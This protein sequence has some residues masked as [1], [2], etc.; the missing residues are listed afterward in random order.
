MNAKPDLS[1]TVGDLK[2]KNPII[3]GSGEMGR[4]ARGLIKYAE[5][6]CSAVVSKSVLGQPWGGNPAPWNTYS[7][8][9]Y[10]LGS[11]GDPGIGFK[12]MVPEIKKAKEAIKDNAFVEV[13]IGTD[14][15]EEFTEMAVEFEKAGADVIE[16]KLVG[17]PNYRP[18]PTGPPNK[19]A[20][21]YWESTPEL[22]E[23]AVRAIKSVVKIPVWV[24]YNPK[25]IESIRA[26]ERGG[27][28]G[29]HAVG[30]GVLVRGLTMCTN[31]KGYIGQPILGDPTG[32]GLK[33]FGSS[34]YETITRIAEL[35]RLTK[36]PL[37]PSGGVA[38]ASDVIQ[39][40]MAGAAAV[41]VYT[42]IAD[43]GLKWVQR[44]LAD[45][46]EWMVEMGVS[47]L[48]EIRGITLKYLPPIAG[49]PVSAPETFG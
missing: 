32:T 25:T 37:T 45:I 15:K 16:L 8:K 31:I 35:A 48:D 41:Q 26:V 7:A 1:V 34:V 33:N 46:E 20:S 14:E 10:L 27:A 12:A 13:S 23:E 36:L 43:G 4:T 2:L 28:N 9:G 19:I 6:G 39:F 17:C 40:I 21:H 3:L 44:T 22:S 18:D 38:E 24:K 42:G 5:V 30:G 47:S 49:V 11:Q 29:M